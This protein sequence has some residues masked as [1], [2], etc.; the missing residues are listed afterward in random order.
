MLFIRNIR[1]PE[2]ARAGIVGSFDSFGL[3]FAAA[4]SYFGPAEIAAL[5]C[6]T[7]AVVFVQGC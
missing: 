3:G 1:V 7:E 6:W 4:K 5:V 2:L